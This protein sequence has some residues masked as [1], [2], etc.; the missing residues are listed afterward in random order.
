MPFDDVLID[1]IKTGIDIVEAI[2]ERV[3]LK[4]S[5]K[6]F[7]GCCPFHE[8]STPSFN[9]TPETQLFY[10]FGCG[11]G[12]DAITF[13]QKIDGISFEDAVRGLAARAGV[14]L[15][16]EK[17]RGSKRTS[18][19][20]AKKRSAFT[21]PQNHEANKAAIV[22][23]GAVSDKVDELV[24][25][26]DP[27]YVTGAALEAELAAWAKA[28]GSDVWSAKQLLKEKLGQG[29]GCEKADKDPMAN[30]SASDIAD[31][32]KSIEKEAGFLTSDYDA[33]MTKIAFRLKRPVKWFQDFYMKR[34]SEFVKNTDETFSEVCK[35]S[36]QTVP[37]LIP[38]LLYRGST[39]LFHA[40]GGCGKTLF[41]YNLIK[42]LSVTGEFLGLP[43][44]EKVRC[45]L[46]QVDE[47]EIP[48][49]ERIKELGLDETDNLVNLDWSFGLVSTLDKWI[50]D[51]NLGCV[52]IDSFFAAQ[53]FAPT[54][55]N[56]SD[57]AAILMR[58]RD[59][60][61]R[62]KANIIVLHHSNKQGFARGTGAITGAVSEVWHLYAPDA[63]N[64][65][66]YKLKPSERIFECEKTRM[67]NPFKL[68]LALDGES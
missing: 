18:H 62:T 68:A 67:V 44:V 3:E 14:R 10:C 15:P 34:L 30:L 26:Y 57:H 9:V 22:A 58:L 7:V 63:E 55:E 2:G 56:D 4:R 39:T 24:R 31:L 48:F 27:P 61:Q 43:V 28:T 50:E 37:W 47:P 25:S 6:G 38:D 45:G 54:R 41:M 8:D 32:L 33:A 36:P 46:I 51:N 40:A 65:R 42:G 64:D 52:I 59:V 5:G 29:Q 11:E 23:I 35:R 19:S 66:Q 16:T 1:Q 13:L 21:K 20:Q 12:G 17:G 53:K 60:A 49:V